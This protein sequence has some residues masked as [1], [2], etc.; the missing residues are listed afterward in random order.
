MWNVNKRYIDNKYFTVFIITFF[1]VSLSRMWKSSSLCSKLKKIYNK[2][3]V[4]L[5]A[6]LLKK[7]FEHFHVITRNMRCSKYNKDNK[8]FLLQDIYKGCICI[9]IFT[10]VTL[11]LFKV[12]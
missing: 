1:P 3:D 4:S 5:G 8:P 7:S 11:R 12:L 10:S 6:R 2:K 9:V